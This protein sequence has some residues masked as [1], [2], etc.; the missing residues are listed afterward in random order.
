M[1]LY[2]IVPMLTSFVDGPIEIKPYVQGFFKAR[3]SLYINLITVA[4]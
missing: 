4:V 2:P 1:G 3:E